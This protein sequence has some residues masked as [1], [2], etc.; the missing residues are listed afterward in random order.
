MVASRLS[1][2]NQALVANGSRTLASLSENRESRRVLDTVWNDG[3]VEYCL[4]QGFWEFAIRTQEITYDPSVS[5]D[6]GYQYAFPKPEDYIRTYSI[7]SDEDFYNPIIRYSDETNYWFTDFDT[8]FVQYVSNDEDYG[9][10]YA[11]WP[12][13]FGTLVHSYLASQICERLTQNASK[14]QRLDKDLE[15]AIKDARSKSAM[16]KPVKFM[17]L[18]TWSRARMGGRWGNFNA[19]LP[20]T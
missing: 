15:D 6:F 9:F 19:V 13:T 20:S 2:Y 1:L 4:E 10:N 16:N 14:K 5:T 12:E 17:H 3:A 8:I 18:G 11:A 7:C